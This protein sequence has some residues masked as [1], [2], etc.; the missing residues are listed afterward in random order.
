MKTTHLIKVDLTTNMGCMLEMERGE[1]SLCP[2]PKNARKVEGKVESDLPCLGHF[3]N[4]EKDLLQP[5]EPP[6]LALV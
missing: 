3:T 4:D 5:S 6:G 2:D 1:M